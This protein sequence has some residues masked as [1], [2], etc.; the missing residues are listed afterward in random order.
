MAPVSPP[1]EE[2]SGRLTSGGDTEMVTGAPSVLGSSMEALQAGARR[3]EAEYVSKKRARM[4][5][6]PQGSAVGA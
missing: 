3:R 6:T 5:D 1:Q 2:T 4:A